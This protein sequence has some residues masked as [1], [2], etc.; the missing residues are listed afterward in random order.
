[1]AVARIVRELCTICARGMRKWCKNFEQRLNV[2]A[3][4]SMSRQTAINDDDVMPLLVAIV[5]V[6]LIKTTMNSVSSTIHKK[7]RRRMFFVD[8]LM[9][10]RLSGRSLTSQMI[11]SFC[12][13][14]TN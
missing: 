4:I 1:M 3:D 7:C 5:D 12:S 13:V 2:A 10:K 8:G 11:W 6:G 9:R 14:M